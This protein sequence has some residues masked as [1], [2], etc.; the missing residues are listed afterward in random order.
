MSSDPGR[1]DLVSAREAPLIPY[2]IALGRFL[3]SYA[4]VESNVLVV[5]GVA[6]KVTNEV[7]QSIFS[8][9]RASAA[10][11]YIKRIADAQNWP[12]EQV[13]LIKFV[14]DQLGEVTRVRN[15][16]CIT[17][18]TRQASKTSGTQPTLLLLT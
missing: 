4:I 13:A 1:V 10:L 6:T 15:D 8:G 5:L 17:V 16:N 9:T 3:S 11:D 14:T 2:Y 12:A 18:L 7:R